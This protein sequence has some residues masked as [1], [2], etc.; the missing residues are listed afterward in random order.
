ML[1]NRAGTNPGS[2][3]TPHS[4]GPC[5]L[6]FWPAWSL[7]SQQRH[8]ELILIK[9]ACFNHSLQERRNDCPPVEWRGVCGF[10]AEFDDCIG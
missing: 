10:G 8:S 4:V 7:F 2:V 6:F 5:E 1:T 9:R 3:A